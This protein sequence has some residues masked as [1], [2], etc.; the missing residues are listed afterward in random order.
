MN[1]QPGDEVI[2]TSEEH[3]S[4]IM[5]W[6]NL[7]NRMGIQIKKLSLASDLGNLMDRLDRMISKNTRLLSLSHVTTDTGI[8]LPAAEISGG[9]SLFGGLFFQQREQI[10]H[11]F[12]IRDVFQQLNGVLA[13]LHIILA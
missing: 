1:W 3:P 9:G 5:L 11:Q 6:L 2:V 4:G 8:R 7:A 12:A 13:C 10:F